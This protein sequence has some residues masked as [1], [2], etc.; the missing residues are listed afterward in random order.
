MAESVELFLVKEGMCK[1]VARGKWASLVH[2]SH[3]RYEGPEKRARLKQ[4]EPEPERLA[5]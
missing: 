5:A 2:P 1:T 4:S 3:L